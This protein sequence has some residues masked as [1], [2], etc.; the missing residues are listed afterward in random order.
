MSILYNTLCNMRYKMTYFS[1]IST[2]N[3]QNKITQIWIYLFLVLSNSKGLWDCSLN[4]LL[5]LPP[6]PSLPISSSKSEDLVGLIRNVVS[7]SNY[8]CNR[9]IPLIG[10]LFLYIPSPRTHWRLFQNVSPL[11]DKWITLSSGFQKGKCWKNGGGGG[12]HLKMLVA[13]T[14]EIIPWKALT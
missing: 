11:Q 13:L 12:V 3:L 10:S 6:I 7:R 8:S 1:H 14:N 9:I 5:T 2:I 4:R